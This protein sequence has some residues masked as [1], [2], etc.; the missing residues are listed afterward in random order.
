M[1]DII[2]PERP[3]IDPHHHLWDRRF[4][5]QPAPCATDFER[6]I[7]LS[8]LYLLDQLNADMKAGHNIVATVFLECGAFYRAD[9]PPERRCVGETEFVNGVAAMSASGLYGPARA[10]AG[11]VGHADLTRGTAV[12]PVLEAHLAAAPER[13]RGIR[14]SP[15]WDADPDVLGMLQRNPPGLLADPA[16]RAGLAELAALGL[17][18][19]CWLLAPQL[20][21]L[22]AMARAV[23]D[24]T[25]ICD[26]LATPLGTASYAGRR[27]ADFVEWAGNIKRLAACPNVV[28][29]V[30]GLAMPFGG[31]A[32]FMA[33]PMA[34]AEMLA[35]EWQ[36]WIESAIA[37]FGADRCM[38]ESNFPVDR[39]TCDYATLWNAFKLVSAAASEDE[40]TALFSGT[41]A[42]VYRLSL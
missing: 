7:G 21:E 28:M 1:A 22:I 42:R 9:G 14:H 26:H 11:I 6:V 3:I 38:F 36:P 40:K 27:N 39:G 18:Y 10:C 19:D 12:R 29:K 8:P 24:L 2:D 41:A 23:P 37:A 33:D 32:S 30:G 5:P 31:F 17:S 34:S 25:I 20:P 35:K 13:F 4:V 15:A 16:F